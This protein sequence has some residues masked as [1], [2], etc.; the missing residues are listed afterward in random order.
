MNVALIVQDGKD[1]R[2]LSQALEACG[3]AVSTAAKRPS[4]AESRHWTLIAARAPGAAGSRL[5]LPKA[6]PGGA[7]ELFL[8]EPSL[9]GVAGLLIGQGYTS[10]SES[11]REGMI[12]HRGRLCDNDES[13]VAE[14]TRSIINANEE[15]LLTLRGALQRDSAADA[16][17]LAHRLKSVAR[18]LACLG[19]A[20]VC[21]QLEA[22]AKARGLD[23]DAVALA[24]LIHAGFTEINAVLSCVELED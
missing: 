14:L 6:A 17:F 8:P 20:R 24:D 18:M 4:P 23:A 19:L 7:A 5:L 11:E 12:A 21:E 3:L 13:I 1:A 10:L 16:G 22:R 2:A 9:P 15:D